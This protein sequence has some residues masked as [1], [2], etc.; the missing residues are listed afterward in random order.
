MATLNEIRTYVQRL[1]G[2]ENQSVVV[3]AELDEYINEGIG[4]IAKLTEMYALNSTSITTTDAYGRISLPTD[5]IKV[6]ELRY[7]NMVLPLLNPALI[8]Y[9][10]TE[11]QQGE[12]IGWYLWDFDQIQLWPIKANGTDL[13]IT[14]MY[15][16]YPAVA[17][18][19]D[20]P[21]IPT[22][23]QKAGAGMYALYKCYMKVGD[24]QMANS[25]LG[26]FNQKIQDFIYNRD[27]PLEGIAATVSDTEGEFTVWL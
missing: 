10:Y 8:K 26:A 21:T 15:T 23:L 18:G 6:K 14:L 2:D 24:M 17:A 13:T 7:N 11:P 19:T 5:F 20:V 3:N 27:N 16:A 9:R 1:F 25:A 4:E 22:F 12:P